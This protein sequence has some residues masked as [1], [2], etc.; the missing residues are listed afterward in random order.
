MGSQFQTVNWYCNQR[1]WASVTFKASAR[2]SHSKTIQHFH[3]FLLGPFQEDNGIL[4]CCCH[5]LAH[6]KIFSMGFERCLIWR[7]YGKKIPFPC[8][9]CSFSP[10][11]SACPSRGDFSSFLFS[12]AILSVWPS[13]PS[14]RQ[15]GPSPSPGPKRENIRFFWFFLQI[16][17]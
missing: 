14:Q 1:T 15:C 13:P 9:S 4:H 16:Q 6:T 3:F 7:A 2:I 5:S 17:L 8:F 10:A 12:S 11:P